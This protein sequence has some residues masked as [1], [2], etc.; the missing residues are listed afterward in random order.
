MGM[1]ISDDRARHVGQVTLAACVAGPA[2]ILLALLFSTELPYLFKG[3]WFIAYCAGIAVVAYV[4]AAITARAH[5]ADAPYLDD[6][7]R[8]G[9]EWREGTRAAPLVPFIYLLSTPSERQV[10]APRPQISV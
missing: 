4:V 2:L 5:M 9:W 1:Q 3:W 6:R 8:E 7:D 10:G